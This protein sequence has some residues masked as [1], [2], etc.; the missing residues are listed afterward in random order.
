ME[1][2]HGGPTGQRQLLATLGET[3][4]RPCTAIAAA[5]L[6]F[7]VRHEGLMVRNQLAVLRDAE[8]L[9]S[10]VLRLVQGT[11]ERP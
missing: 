9:G 11:L 7:N 6:S 8:L 1:L 2:R 3:R 4:S 5:K 10:N